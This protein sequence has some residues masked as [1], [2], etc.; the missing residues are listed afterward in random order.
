MKVDILKAALEKIS[1]FFHLMVVMDTRKIL[2]EIIEIGNLI[3]LLL[4]RLCGD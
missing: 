4:E 1:E 3:E 2:G